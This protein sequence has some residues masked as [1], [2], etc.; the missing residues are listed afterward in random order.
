MLDRTKEVLNLI[1][2]VLVSF[3][4]TDFGQVSFGSLGLALGAGLFLLTVFLCKMLWG[5]NKFRHNYAG[6]EIPAEYDESASLLR[7]LI[8]AFPKFLLGLSAVFLL[9][10]L[11]N[12]YLP[13]TKIETIVE[14]RERA[15]LIDIS[16]SMGW[17][18]GNSGKS[19]CEV[20]RDAHLRFLRMRRGQN[21]RVS[22]WVFSNNPYMREGFIID[23]DVYMMQVEDAPC[24]MV[25]RAHWSLPENDINDQ[26][27]DNIVPRDKVKIIETEAATNLIGGLRAVI[28]YFDEEGRKDIRRKSLLIVTD[29]A[30]EADPETEFME[31]RKRN[32][33]PYM[34]HVKPNEI[35]ERQFNASWKL[36]TAE[37][38]KQ[39]V[40]QYGG[41]VFDVSDRAS[42]ER[43]YAEINRLE[44]APFDIV[45]HLFRVLI[46][47]RPLMVALVLSFFA[48]ILGVIVRE[49]FP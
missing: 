40:R 9:I 46:F 24:V 41:V 30:V 43:A 44:T 13:R 4:D 18:F 16:S 11:A 5:R 37:L 27:L 10:T 14:S 17:P 45:R 49:E 25:N 47:Q 33:I 38:T 7:R 3:K 31:L 20:A 22:L 2:S 26:Y 6:H 48:M 8:C 39:R 42:A 1:W 29:A 28:K 36:E 23:D 32:I 35:G 21:D 15:E 12:P 34:I 19:A